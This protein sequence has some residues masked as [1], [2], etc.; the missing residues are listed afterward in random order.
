[1]PTTI[2][3][4]N[5][6][7]GAV[8]TGDGSGVLELQSGGVTGITINGANVT[9]TGALTVAGGIPAGSLTGTLGVANG[10]TGAVTLRVVVLRLSPLQLLFQQAT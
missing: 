1:M 2:N 10:G 9:V 4:S 8:V 3:A 5:T 7:G 6:S